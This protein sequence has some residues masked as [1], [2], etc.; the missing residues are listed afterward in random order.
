M[1]SAKEAVR[2]S[3]E[4]Q[5]GREYHAKVHAASAAVADIVARQR[6]RKFQP[7]VRPDDVVLEYGVGT[8]LNL[9]YLK[10]RRRIGYDVSDA[11]RELCERAGIE[12]TSD[13]AEVKGQISV[14][15]CHHTLEHVP[16]P[17]DCLGQISQVLPPG[18]RLILC[19][20]FETHSSY[21]RYVPDDPN[22]HLFSWNALTLGNLAAATGLSVDDVRISPFGYEQRLAFLSRYIGDWA[23]RSGLAVLRRLRPADEV[24][25][26]ATRPGATAE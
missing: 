10:C 9:R 22:R 18:G 4:G 20:P 6:A 13:L 5:A 19:V 16:D 17:L 25:L 26:Q 2:Y 11:G 23:Y 1:Y 7:L 24:F 15:I 3:Y 8:G 14:A 12:F 21:R